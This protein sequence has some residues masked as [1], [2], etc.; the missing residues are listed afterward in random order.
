MEIVINENLKFAAK[1]LG[2]VL[3]NSVPYKN[4]INAREKFRN[5]ELAKKTA[6]EY[7]SVVNNYQMK[8][9]WGGITLEDENKIEEAQKIAMGNK[10]LNDYYTSQEELIKFYQELNDYISEK[11]KFNFA[12]LAKPAGGCCG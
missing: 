7:H 1:S 3:L 6:R 9:K 2:K 10:V 4:F 12:G 8:A 11:L 5:D